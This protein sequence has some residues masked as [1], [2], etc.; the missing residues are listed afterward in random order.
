LTDD[1]SLGGSQ[2]IQNGLEF[3]GIV[4]VCAAVRFHF[5]GNFFIPPVKDEIRLL[6]GGR[7]PKKELGKGIREAFST[8]QILDYE[9]HPARP[10]N[11]VVVQLVESSNVEQVVQ[12]PCVTDE[13]SRS[14]YQA[15]ANVAKVRRQ[16]SDAKNAFQKID[17]MLNR[18]VVHPQRVSQSG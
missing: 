3:L 9:S 7:A 4:R 8:H 18:V 16:T 15:F 14:F 13:Y 1:P 11:R 5:Y 6:A 10:A 12:K 2:V 17:A